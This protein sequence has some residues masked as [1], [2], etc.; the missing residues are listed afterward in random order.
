MIKLESQPDDALAQSVQDKGK[1]I[2]QLGN[3]ISNEKLKLM[4][5]YQL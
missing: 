4:K 1:I 3:E 2:S 5:K